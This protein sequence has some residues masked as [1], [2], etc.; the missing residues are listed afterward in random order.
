MNLFFFQN[1]VIPSSS[2]EKSL[3]RGDY[4]FVSKLSYG[5]RIPQ[6]PLTIPFT[7]NVIF[8]KE[9]YS[10]AIQNEYRRLKGLRS[11]ERGD[12]V[13][14]GFPHGDGGYQSKGVYRPAQECRMKINEVEDFCP[15]CIRAIQ[16]ITDF[17]TAQ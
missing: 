7:H 8:G 14:F 12:Y 1:Y 2:L 10:T 3:L 5:P 11:V 4:L 17:Y 15:V 9:S 13:V 6:T 16:R